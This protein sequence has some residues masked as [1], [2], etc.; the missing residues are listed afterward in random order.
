MSEFDLNDLEKISNKQEIID[1]LVDHEIIKEKKFRKQLAYE[2]EIAYL[3]LELVRLQSYIIDQKKRV[4]IIFEGRDAAGKGGTISRIVQNLNPKK[5][6]VI[7]LPKPNDSENGQWYFQR[8][9]KHLPNE[10]EIVFFDRS[11]YNRAVVEPV[12]GFCTDEEYHKFL[13]QVNDVEKLLKEDGI[14]IIKIY[15]SI[16]K[17]EQAERLAERKNDSLKQWKLGIL[18]QQAQ[19][20]WDM[21]TKYINHLFLETS[22]RLNPWFEVKTDDKKEARLAAMKLILSNINGFSNNILAENQSIIKHVKN[23]NI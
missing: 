5:Y 4:L 7:S 8:Y 17:Q 6:K 21:Y 18:D 1:F 10:G 23:G 22:P 15:L 20:K 16:S 12:F 3:Q 14:E 13:H 9:L 19:E 2:K 11:W